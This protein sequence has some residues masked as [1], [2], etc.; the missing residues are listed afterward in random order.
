MTLD[1]VIQEG[2]RHPEPFAERQFKPGEA[3]AKIAVSAVTP[4]SIPA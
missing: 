1:E 2:L 3:K 4:V